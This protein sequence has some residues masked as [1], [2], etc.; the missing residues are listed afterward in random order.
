M[1]MKRPYLL[2]GILWC[3]LLVQQAARAEDQVVFEE[4]F[5]DCNGTGGTDGTYGGSAGGGDIGFD[6]TGWTSNKCGGGSQCVKF[7]TGSANGVLSTPHIS[8]KEGTT[9][10]LTFK[11]AGWLTKEGDTTK[12]KLTISAEGCTL[13]GDISLNNAKT[14]KQIING[15]WTEYTVYI[16]N[17]TAPVVITFTG[18]RGFLDNVKIT[19]EPGGDI[20][21]TVP[22]PTLTEEF[23]FWSNTIEPTKR[24][25]TITP[26]ENTRTHY[27]LDGSEPSL[28]DGIEITEATN[29]F[30]WGTTT[31]K[32]ISTKSSYTS[33]VITKTYT[34]GEPV[35]S[36]ADFCALADGTEAKLFL[37]AEQNARITAVNDKQFTLKDDTNTLLFDFGDV[38]FNPTPAVNQHVAGWIIGKKQTI[39]GTAWFVATSNTTPKY[40][41]F[42]NRVTEPDVTGIKAVTNLQESEGDTYYTLSGLLVKAPKKGIY[43]A[44]KK[45]LIVH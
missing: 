5:K 35:N 13:S 17:I 12:N 30:V 1:L 31:I 41:A 25:V 27:T 16:S 38:A 19:G 34:L 45:K 37:N 21:V 11:V 42:A 9:A 10:T 33:N 15:E 39:D 6:N 24:I 8:L 23:T 44:N 29:L 7:G 22:E 3:F 4:T 43:I 14:D 20:E 28:T 40:M 26:A 36:I 18:K 2:F 32:A